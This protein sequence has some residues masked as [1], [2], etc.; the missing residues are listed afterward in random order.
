MPPCRPRDSC[1]CAR[2]TLVVDGAQDPGGA[3]SRPR[4]SCTPSRCCPW[5]RYVLNCLRRATDHHHPVGADPGRE[6][7]AGGALVRGGGWARSEPPRCAPP[8]CT[9]FSPPTSPPSARRS[10]RRSCV[11]RAQDRQR[12]AQRVL[13]L[14]RMMANFLVMGARRPSEGLPRHAAAPSG[15][16]VLGAGFRGRPLPH[17]RRRSG[18]SWLVAPTAAFP[19]SPP[20]VAYGFLFFDGDPGPGPPRSAGWGG[21]TVLSRDPVVFR[22]ERSG[23]S[24]TRPVLRRDPQSRCT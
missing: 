24:R 17:R 8:R 4:W 12:G 16:H 2:A 7:S 18:N 3:R 22:E 1:T 14:H 15:R 9:A 23:E 6:R 13:L 21:S 20:A 10:A 5:R 11:R 19:G